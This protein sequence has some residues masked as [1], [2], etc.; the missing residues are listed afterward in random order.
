[1]RAPLG[2]RLEVPGRRPVDVSEILTD[3][4]YR[5]GVPGGFLGGSG[6]LWASI[7]DY[8]IRANTRLTITDG[9][10][11]RTLWQGYLDSPGDSFDE[12]GEGFDLNAQGAMTLAGDQAEQLLYLDSSYE[13]WRA[14]D[15]NDENL[16]PSGEGSAAAWPDTEQ[17]A[18]L[19]QFASGTPIGRADEAR[20]IHDLADT[21]PMG[22]G[23]YSFK[24]KSGLNSNGYQAR[25]T[26]SGNGV[27][28]Q[29]DMQTSTQFM[30]GV[31]GIN[32]GAAGD[33]LKVRLRRVKGA[34]N[35]GT[36][37]I[38]T[39]FAD[40]Y[41]V[42]NR[43][44][45]FGDSQLTAGSLPNLTYVLASEVV[46]DMVARL[47]PM[48][49]PAKVYIDASSYHI[50]QMTYADP[51]RAT[52]VLEDLELFEP[53]W[54]WRVT[55]AGADQKHGFQ[56]TKWPTSP[57]YEISL[58]DGYSA[59][60]G[61]STLANRVAV[62][63]VDRK[64]RERTEIVTRY[65]P[66]LGGTPANPL[67]GARIIDAEKV[68]L[69]ETVSSLANAQRIGGQYLRLVNNPPKAATA[70]VVR[71]IRD[72]QRAGFVAPWEIEPFTICRLRET[73]ENLRLTEIEMNTD[74]V[75]A[76]LTLGTPRPTLERMIARLR[77][78]RRRKS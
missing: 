66:E 13:H 2:A 33:V 75:T 29:I 45:R 15:R 8:D 70:T 71:P 56:Y 7:S 16:A 4:T 57:R 68:S 50:D 61:E 42:G 6:K 55:A 30:A 35:V 64:G 17:D 58:A 27:V 41:V 31:L 36:D 40:P 74:S 54:A 47:M 53:N 22:I 24:V 10:T 5:L 69:D 23:G 11:A 9:R 46:E 63:W 28:E 77:K 20:M 65:V 60:G 39:G 32:I 72:L 38:W 76:S 21:A 67:Q 37:K 62:G 12:T 49:D 59:P 34:T 14:D 25:V 43:W 1:M 19:L 51:T 26:L 73:G 18:L 52:G 3:F 48:V 78:P 44:D